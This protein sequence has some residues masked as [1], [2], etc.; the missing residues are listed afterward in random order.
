[1][2]ALRLAYLLLLLAAAALFG[3][4]LRTGQ[5]LQTDLN[6]LLPQESQWSTVQI[7]AEQRKTQQLNQ[8]MIALAGTP[9]LVES[10]RFLQQ[11]AEQWRATDLFAEVVFQVQ[12]DIQQFRQ[13]LDLLKLV[14]L[15]ESIREQLIHA[16]QIYFQEYAEQ[17]VT[18]FEQAN[19]LPLG[20]D[21]LPRP[22]GCP[23]SRNKTESAGTTQAGCFTSNKKRDVMPKLTI[24]CGDCYAPR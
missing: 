14:T 12:P 11:L 18:P 6:A 2:T 4:L 16:P 17:L 19:L 20:Q 3:S 9:S 13:E 22:L 10:G 24:R 5:W 7:Q 15:P 23:L 1:M 8:Q 21:W